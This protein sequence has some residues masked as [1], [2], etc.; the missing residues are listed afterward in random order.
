MFVRGDR[1]AQLPKRL[2]LLAARAFESYARTIRVREKLQQP[3]EIIDLAFRVAGTGSLG[4][5][6]IAVL[7]RGKG[8]RDGVV[9]LRHEGARHSRCRRSCSGDRAIDPAARVLAGLD[10]CVPHPRA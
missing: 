6:R 10:A 8:G 3:F 2:E 7:T 9:D 5:L 4:K 1:Y